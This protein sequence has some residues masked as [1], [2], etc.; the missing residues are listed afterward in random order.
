MTTLVGPVSRGGFAAN[1]VVVRERR[2]PGLR[3]ED[4][5]SAQRRGT[6]AELP[7]LEVFDERSVTLH[8][9]PAFQRLQR[10]T[11]GGRRIQ[12]AQTFLLGPKAILA[13]TFSAELEDF[14]SQ[15]PALRQITESL[16]LFDPDG[17]SI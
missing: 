3:I 15:L 14:D 1:V 2:T 6:A 17:I 7:G 5:A 16:R 12:Q 13:L 9:M 11:A 4:Y 10:F 8:G